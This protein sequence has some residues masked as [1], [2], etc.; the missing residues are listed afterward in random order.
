MQ[1]TDSTD[2]HAEGSNDRRQTT[3]DGEYRTDTYRTD[4]NLMGR[5]QKMDSRQTRRRQ[6]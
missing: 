4:S 1:K 5:H 3:D 6:Q 2:R